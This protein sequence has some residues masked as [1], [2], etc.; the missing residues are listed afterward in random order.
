MESRFSGFP[1]TVL[2]V[3]HCTPQLQ[4]SRSK[5]KSCYCWIKFH[6]YRSS[7]VFFCPTVAPPVINTHTVKIFTSEEDVH[8]LQ[9]L[10]V[11]SLC[12]LV[13]LMFSGSVGVTVPPSVRQDCLSLAEVGHNRSRLAAAMRRLTETDAWSLRNISGL[14]QANPASTGPGRSSI[15]K[16]TWGAAAL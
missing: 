11:M 13:G 12:V 9:L 7:V 2:Q 8:L 5:R 3:N 6:N 16:K 10:C 4:R 14:C 1:A 15:R